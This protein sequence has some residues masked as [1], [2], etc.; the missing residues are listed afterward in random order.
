MVNTFVIALHYITIHLNSYEVFR[1]KNNS[2]VFT[3][4]PQRRFFVRRGRPV[5]T[6]GCGTFRLGQLGQVPSIHLNLVARYPGTAGFHCRSGGNSPGTAFRHIVVGRLQNPAGSARQRYFADIVCAGDDFFKKHQSPA[7]FFR[8]L[9]S[10]SGFRAGRFI[11]AK[12]I[13]ERKAINDN[14]RSAGPG[15]YCIDALIATG[16]FFPV[17]VLCPRGCHLRFPVRRR[18]GSDP[19]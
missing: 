17:P 13:G 6:L 16:R 19:A 11:Q 10:R 7:G 4:S 12:G 5:R 14:A 3:Y 1:R 2:L 18:C 8:I 9:R 15:H